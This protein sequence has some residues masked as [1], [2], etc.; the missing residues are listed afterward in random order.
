MTACFRQFTA[1]I[2]DVPAVAQAVTGKT[3]RWINPLDYAPHCLPTLTSLQLAVVPRLKVNAHF[4][5]S[6]RNQVPGQCI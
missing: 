5:R 3:V 1:P 6:L 4:R 2:T